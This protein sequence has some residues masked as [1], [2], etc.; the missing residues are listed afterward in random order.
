MERNYRNIPDKFC[1]ICGKFILSGQ[2]RN[3]T[4]AV[5]ESYKAYFGI[6]LGDQ[7]KTFAPHKCCKTCVE[8]LRQWR[9][10]K[11]KRE[12]TVWRTNDM[13]RGKRSCDRL[14]LLYDQYNR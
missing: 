7:D 5:K 14:L 8:G 10:G 1:Y 2:E 11:K 3:I 13:E 6:L 9:Q 12:L 4:E